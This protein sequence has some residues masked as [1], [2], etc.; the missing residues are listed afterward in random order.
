MQQPS[1]I[2][3]LLI[4]APG[5][6]ESKTPRLTPRGFCFADDPTASVRQDRQQQQRDDVGDLDRR[7]HGRTGYRLGQ[8]VEICCAENK[9]R[10]KADGSYPDRALGF[11]LDQ[12]WQ[13]ELQ[14]VGVCDHGPSP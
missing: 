3:N 10:D 13:S 14:L 2:R 7:V 6:C 5:D 12:F 1:A 8:Q 4:I 11:A 9:K